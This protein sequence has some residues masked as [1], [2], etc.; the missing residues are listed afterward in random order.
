MDLA[1]LHSGG[2]H[3]MSPPAGQQLSLAGGP[4]VRLGLG[5][6]VSEL[7]GKTIDQR[8]CEVDQPGNG[9][10]SGIENCDGDSPGDFSDAPGL[11]APHQQTLESQES[12]APWQV[13]TRRSSRHERQHSA[14]GQG[15]AQEKSASARQ[16]SSSANGRVT[17]QN[18]RSQVCNNGPVSLLSITSCSYWPLCVKSFAQLS[19]VDWRSFQTIRMKVHHHQQIK[20]TSHDFLHFHHVMVGGLQAIRGADDAVLLVGPFKVM[21]SGARPSPDALLLSLVIERIVPGFLSM[22][23][24]SFV[25]ALLGVN[26]KLEELITAIT[27]L[28]TQICQE[29][30]Y[31]L[32][33]LG[34]HNYSTRQ[35]CNLF[36]SVAFL[37]KHANEN[38]LT[39]R[40]QQQVGISW[41][42]K[43]HYDT[44]QRLTCNTT[45]ASVPVYLRDLRANLRAICLW[46]EA[47][48]FGIAGGRERYRLI[49]CFARVTESTTKAMERLDLQPDSSLFAI[50]QVVAQ[51]SFCFLKH[52]S[53]HLGFDRTISLLWG[54]LQHIHHWP[55]LEGLAFELRLTL[56]GIVLMKCEILLRKRNKVP[57]SQVWLGYE[58]MLVSLL[59]KCNEFM[60]DYYPPFK[61]YSRSDFATQKK[62]AQL[63]LQLKESKFYRLD[64]EI[65]KTPRQRILDNLCK[66]RRAFAEGWVLSRNHMEI[67]TIELAKWYFLA[68]EYDAGARTLMRA[69]FDNIKLSW[70][71]GELLARHNMY[72]AAVDEFQ[73]IKALMTDLDGVDQNR[74]DQIDDQIAMTQLRWY[75]TDNNIDHLISAYQLSVGLLGRCNP[76]DRTR[77]EGGLAHIVNAM[78]NSGLRFEDYVEQ[79]LV[80]GYMVKDGCGIKSWHHFSILMHVRH[81]LGLTD[82][83]IVHKL[84]S[85]ISSHHQIYPELGKKS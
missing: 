14:A 22:L 80:L 40:L 3:R 75:R 76:R 74:R 38:D 61:S 28:L 66:C 13:V 26:H 52:L 37:F 44:I 59:A 78:K 71:K 85:E 53:D 4:S 9:D 60:R 6:L 63:N 83:N 19:K 39:R 35:Q 23:G 69:P 55:G 27:E 2:S 64:C 67:G 5:Q 20:I 56:L 81:K 29:D 45:R 41:L 17:G 57:C 77:Y 15:D 47:R 70:R 36:S 32:D 8:W 33:R 21:L 7:P 11:C 51:W 25:G 49:D 73:R 16:L 12:G 31:W 84:A 48:F 46:L 30:G 34:W 79:T 18:Q 42:E 54:S 68:G 65:R 62:D 24:E 10:Q 50:W 43:Q 82:V 58:N 72:Q 1:T